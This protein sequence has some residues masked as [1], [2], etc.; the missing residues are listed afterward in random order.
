M[1]VF[2]T[3]WLIIALVITAIVLFLSN[4]PQKVMPIPLQTGGITKTKYEEGSGFPLHRGRT[5]DL[6]GT[7][8]KTRGTL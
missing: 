6:T 1:S 4:L 5:L 7:A 8:P 2:E 3:K